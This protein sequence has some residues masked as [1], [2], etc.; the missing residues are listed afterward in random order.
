MP[1]IPKCDECEKDGALTD[2]LSSWLCF[3]HTISYCQEQLDNIDKTTYC[4]FCKKEIRGDIMF[5][6]ATEHFEEI[7]NARKK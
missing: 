1:E 6:Y 5:H 4:K 2:G 7:E 3:Q